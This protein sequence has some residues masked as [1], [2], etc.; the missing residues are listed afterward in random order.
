MTEITKGLVVMALIGTIAIGATTVATKRLQEGNVV[1]SG[2]SPLFRVGPP[3]FRVSGLRVNQTAVE[4]GENV[5]ISV[6]VKN[7]GGT[8]GSYMLDL[9][10]DGVSKDNK[11]VNLD[12]GENTTVSFTVQKQTVGSHSVRIENLVG[13]F[14]VLS[15]I[16]VKAEGPGLAVIRSTYKESISIENGEKIALRVAEPE[17]GTSN[18]SIPSL[19]ATPATGAQ[20]VKWVDEN[21]ETVTKE[22]LYTMEVHS[23]LVLTAV[24]VYPGENDYN[25]YKRKY[26]PSKLPLDYAVNPYHPN[27]PGDAPSSENIVSI[28]K[29]AFETWDKHVETELFDNNVE[30]TSTKGNGVVYFEEMS[31]SFG[32]AS[33]PPYFRVRID[34][35]TLKRENYLFEVVLHEAGHTLGL[36]HPERRGTVM[37]LPTRTT[38]ARGDILGLKALYGEN[39]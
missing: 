7:V 10:V 15:T 21:G 16:K 29:R 37:G 39:A 12:P 6:D 27:L 36:E 20:F 35:Q 30:V 32:K 3:L 38:L 2:D 1:S 26:E 34:P 33:Y 24:F 19:T 25:L 23:D 18:E 8:K 5:T 28:I 31:D 22:N 14:E 11:G 9:K 13:S 17:E 4:T